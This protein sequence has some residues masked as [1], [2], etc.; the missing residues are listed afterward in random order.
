MNNNNNNSFLELIDVLDKE[1][2]CHLLLLSAAEEMNTAL[3]QNRVED[4]R[5]TSKKYDE[6]T[7]TIKELEEKRLMLSDL[8]CKKDTSKAGHANLLMVIENAPEE[9]KEKISNL[10]GKIKDIVAKISKINYSNQ[11]L[12][13]E[14][15]YS[16]SKMFEMVMNNEK[17]R[18]LAYKKHGKKDLSP[19][20]TNIVDRVI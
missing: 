12:L 4:I 5:R 1:Y 20:T 11:V 14:A 16:A 17:N 9:L 7:F 3:K 19:V 2:A 10:R 18:F 8:I 6:Y 15:L 13:Q